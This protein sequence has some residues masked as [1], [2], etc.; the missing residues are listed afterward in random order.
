MEFRV[1]QHKAKQMQGF[2]A[3]YNV[4]RLVH[5]EHFTYINNAI[6]REK[7]LKGWLRSRKI[8]L[9]E[10]EN[11]DWIDL[12]SDWKTYDN[13]SKEGGVD[14]LSFPKNLKP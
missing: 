6:A 1:W 3:R 11:P 9:I 13:I 7:E 4:D 10:V 2:T 14:V 12:A 5:Y 8:A